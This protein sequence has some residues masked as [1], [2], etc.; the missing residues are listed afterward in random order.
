MARDC[1]GEQALS[2]FVADEFV[3]AGVRKA[4][5]EIAV[6]DTDLAIG[7][8]FTLTSACPD[9][10]DRRALEDQ[11]VSR[12]QEVHRRA[13]QLPEG[14]QCDCAAQQFARLIAK[15]RE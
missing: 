6:S 13:E 2:R 5:D 12:L 15:Q 8:A 14:L 11:L 1:E 7:Q 10:D 3:E 4:L 9:V